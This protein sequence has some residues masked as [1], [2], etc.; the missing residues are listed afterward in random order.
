MLVF[1]TMLKN[2][3]AIAYRRF[4]WASGPEPEELD[5]VCCLPKIVYLLCGVAMYVSRVPPCEPA[6]LLTIR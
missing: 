4:G 1:K 3:A 2:G 6:R 5:V